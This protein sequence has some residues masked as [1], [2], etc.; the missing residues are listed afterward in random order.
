MKFSKFDI[1]QMDEQ[2]FNKVMWDAL[3]ILDD[4]VLMEK[5][6]KLLSKAKKLSK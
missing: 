1:K 3:Q 4:P 2:E 5:L 6:E